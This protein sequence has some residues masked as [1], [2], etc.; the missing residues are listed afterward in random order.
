MNPDG[1]GMTFGTELGRLEGP[2]KEPRLEKGRH[3]FRKYV[4]KS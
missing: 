4:R 3:R 2:K 1:L